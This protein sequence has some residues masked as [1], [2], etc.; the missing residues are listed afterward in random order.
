MT[1]LFVDDDP[2]EEAVEVVTMSTEVVS[3]PRGAEVRSAFMRNNKIHT[4]KLSG[5]E[6]RCKAFSDIF[7][8]RIFVMS[9]NEYNVILDELQL[10]SEQIEVRRLDIVMVVY[11]IYSIYLKHKIAFSTAITN[12]FHEEITFKRS[13]DVLRETYTQNI[14][15]VLGIANINFR[16]CDI[17]YYIR[18]LI[19]ILR[20]RAP[21]HGLEVT[22]EDLTFLS[23]T[24]SQLYQIQE[25][26]YEMF[27]R[28]V[29][30]GIV[31]N[32][33]KSE[34][35]EDLFDTLLYNVMLLVQAEGENIMPLVY[36]EDIMNMMG[37]YPKRFKHMT[38][39]RKLIVEEKESQSS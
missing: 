18:G 32:G 9:T 36:Q 31:K 24:S 7:S 33:F 25:K 37:K 29:L 39:L 22:P 38:K 11:F 20:T 30:I 17:K 8:K 35:M 15:Q 28:V 12:I 10:L 3:M 19:M 5:I 34:N 4:K 26:L 21:F 13:S 6:E 1:D 16:S 14:L 23:S 27:C 2:V